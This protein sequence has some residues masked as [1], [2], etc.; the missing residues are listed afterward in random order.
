MMSVAQ[1]SERALPIRSRTVRSL[2]RGIR[3]VSHVIL[4]HSKDG[5]GRDVRDVIARPSFERL[6]MARGLRMTLVLL[7]V[8]SDDAAVE[9]AA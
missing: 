2:S 4:S 5:P 6:R 3:S 8:D 1:F 7:R 9:T